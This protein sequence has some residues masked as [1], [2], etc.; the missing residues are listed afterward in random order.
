MEK[1]Y[2]ELLTEN[3]QLKQENE[4]L[5]QMIVEALIYIEDTLQDTWLVWNKA[6]KSTLDLEMAK[7]V[8]NKKF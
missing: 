6:N 7:K 1:S 8:L 4:N 5:K 3:Q 2:D